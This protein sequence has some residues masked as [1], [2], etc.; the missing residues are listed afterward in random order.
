MIGDNGGIKVMCDTRTAVRK[1]QPTQ[2]CCAVGISTGC[3]AGWGLF[4]ASLSP[5]AVSSEIK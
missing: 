3:V 2:R 4:G 5:I 1:G